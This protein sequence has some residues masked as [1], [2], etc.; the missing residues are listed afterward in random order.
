[1]FFFFLSHG[2]AGLEAIT[3]S[4]FEAPCVE[5]RHFQLA[6]DKLHPS[7]TPEKLRAFEQLC[8][9]FCRIK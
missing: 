6:L 8:A 1:M 9:K 5:Q 7:L 2:Q 3:E 4:G